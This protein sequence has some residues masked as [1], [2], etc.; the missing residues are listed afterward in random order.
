VL[1]KIGN[2]THQ[3]SHLQDRQKK[4]GGGGF[5][6]VMAGAGGD[7]GSGTEAST[8]SGGLD[9]D[10]IEATYEDWSRQRRAD[11]ADDA[12]M[13]RVDAEKQTYLDVVRKAEVSGGFENPL[14]FLKTLT[15]QE[16]QALQTTQS[17]GEQIDP[18]SL[19]AEGAFNLL[20]P[21]SMARDLDGDGRFAVGT[22]QTI[23]FPPGDAPQAVKDAWEKTTDGMSFDMKLQL[24]MSMHLAGNAD[25][26][27]AGNS[28]DLSHYRN[29]I[30]RAVEGAE[31]NLRAA[32]S[33]QAAFAA[34]ILAGLQ[35]FQAS[36]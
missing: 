9:Y 36:L 32:S 24:Q 34:R 18:S 29:M 21:R 16:L 4:A 33:D 20:L 26:G 5:S 2:A 15:S 25:A 8:V 13:D 28:S 19:T 7:L 17:L 35:L 23:V 3:A 27:L 1:D 30:D 14:D 10:S 22:A 6:D 31:L 12:Y 11:G